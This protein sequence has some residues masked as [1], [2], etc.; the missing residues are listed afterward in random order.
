MTYYSSSLIILGIILII[1]IFA[2][3]SAIFSFLNVVI[4]RLPKKLDFLRGRSMCPKCAH[5]LSFFDLVPILSWVALKGKCRYCHEKISVRYTIVEIMGGIAA[6][7]SVLVFE[8]TP[9]AIFS[10]AMCGIIVCVA[11]IDYDTMEIPDAFHIAILAVGVLSVFLTDYASWYEHLI[12]VVAV[13]VPMLIIAL[14]VPGGFGGGDIKLMAACGLYLGWRSVVFAFFV[15]VIIGGI[16]A[17]IMVTSGKKKR[18]DYIAFGPYLC[19][20]VAAAIFIGDFITEYYLG[21]VFGL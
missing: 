8:F 18:R 13:S 16:S 6:V 4:Y 17:L 9:R 2:F 19:I 21:A 10:F 7:A 14:I 15:S 1:L 3:G 12:G 20:G 5:T 11:Y